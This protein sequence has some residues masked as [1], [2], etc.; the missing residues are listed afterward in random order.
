MPPPPP[1]PPLSFTTPSTLRAALVGAA[2]LAAL[3]AIRARLSASASASQA[4]R[5]A[6]QASRGASQASPAAERASSHAKHAS[7]SLQSLLPAHVN[8]KT[9]A[10]NVHDARVVHASLE[11]EP[12]FKRRVVRGAATLTC[13]I[14]HAGVTHV[15]LD[16]NAL[17]IKAVAVGEDPSKL[18]P[19]TFTLK[20]PVPVIGQPLHVDLP[21]SPHGDRPHQVL[22]RVEYETTPES[23]ATQFLEP[24]QTAG[25]KHPFLFTQAQAVH[26]RSFYPCQDA[27]AVKF[28]WDATVRAPKPLTALMSALSDGAPQDADAARVFRFHQPVPTPSYLVAIAVGE[29]ESHDL[30]PRTRVWAEPSVIARAAKEFEDVETFV[31][32]AESLLTPYVWQRFDFLVMPPSF[33]Y[34]GMENTNLTFVTPSLLAGDKS[35]VDVLI[36][37]LAHS[38]M[39]NLVTNATWDDFFLNEGWT[40]FV[41]RRLV[42]KL[43]GAQREGLKAVI[44]WR[45]LA[46]DVGRFGEKHAFTA[47]HI[48]NEGTTDPDDSFSSVPYEKGAAL[49]EHLERLV[50]GPDVFEPFVRKYVDK[51]KFGVV[52]AA[53][54]RRF[55]NDA[56]PGKMSADAWDTWLLKPGMPPPAPAGYH[57][58]ILVDMAE[59]AATEWASSKSPTA[60]KI[61]A[62][63]WG[64]DQIIVFLEK[65]AQIQE[66]QAGGVDM[67][68]LDG[69]VEF[70]GLRKTGNAELKLRYYTLFLKATREDVFEGVVA[71]LEAYG[72]M[73]YIRPCYRALDK[74]SARGHELAVSTFQRLRGTY[75]PIAAKMVAKDL[76]LS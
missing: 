29:L 6:S 39:G 36:H 66:K 60:P 65:L 68:V 43:H 59:T 1:P 14:R 17:L 61:V 49:M 45:H 56:F 28:T 71:F 38:W 34:G 52:D 5:G 47:L 4:S 3:A 32:A 72:R 64:C 24:M 12:D 50:G 73:K 41:E 30:G 54:F 26:A 19:T 40:V 44:G 13:A 35:L 46:E 51:F 69:V 76:G 2:G 7:T 20:P 15:V 18:K 33:P 42:R 48:P 10:G 23:T 22:V 62:P 31:S 58:T 21:P 53:A 9:S 63:G 75:H 11:L 8:D 57:D 67:S 74:C 16:T 25:K 70:F 37:E 55:F 27:P